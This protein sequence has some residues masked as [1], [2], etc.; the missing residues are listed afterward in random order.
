MSFPS[1]ANDYVETRIT[2]EFL[3]HM[4]GNCAATETTMGYAVINRSLNGGQ[5]NRC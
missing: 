1:P 3:C 4:D 2:V 5:D